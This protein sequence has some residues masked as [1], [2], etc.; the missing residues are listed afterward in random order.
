ERLQLRGGARVTAAE[1]RHVVTERDQ[2]LDEP[3]HH[4]LSSA[5]E[6]WRYCFGQ[7]SHLGDTH[8]CSLL[9]ILSRRCVPTCPAIQRWDRVSLFDKETIFRS[10]GNFLTLLVFP[11]IPS[12][13]VLMGVRNGCRS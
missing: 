3:V 6:F 8:G 10:C 11:H 2:L 4:P 7:W 9:K 13:L 12:V 5:V 1:Q